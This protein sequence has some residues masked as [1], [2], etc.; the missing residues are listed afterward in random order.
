MRWMEVDNQCCVGVCSKMCLGG[1]AVLDFHAIH[2]CGSRI[3]F[4]WLW[5]LL[6]A[7][8]LLVT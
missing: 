3:C 6:H 4:A 5:E 7:M 8:A 2:R 1:L